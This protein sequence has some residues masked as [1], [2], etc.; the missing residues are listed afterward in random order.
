[1]INVAKAAC[2]GDLGDRH[3]SVRHHC[4]SRD[5]PLTDQPPARTFPECS[6]EDPSRLG[7]TEPGEGRYVVRRPMA[8]DV[9]ADGLDGSFERVDDP[10]KPKPDLLLIEKN[11]QLAESPSR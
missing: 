5:Q 11:K 1:M 9:G 8:S 3:R 6:L 7:Q 2:L 4:L 10:A